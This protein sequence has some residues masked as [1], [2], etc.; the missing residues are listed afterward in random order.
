MKKLNRSTVSVSSKSDTAL[1]LLRM[2]EKWPGMVRKEEQF[3]PF[4]PLPPPQTNT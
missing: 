2:F 1:G 3:S 4:T